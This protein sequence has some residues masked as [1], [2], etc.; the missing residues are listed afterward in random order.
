[1]DIAFLKL[2]L[3]WIEH[4]HQTI[5]QSKKLQSRSLFIIARADMFRGNLSHRS[6]GAAMDRIKLHTR[7][8]GLDVD[9]SQIITFPNGLPGFQSCRRWMLFHELDENG[10]P[11][12]GVVIHLQSVDDE[13]LS[14][15]LTEPNLFGFNY[16]MVLSESDIAEL[17]VENVADVLVLMILYRSDSA[18]P[19]PAVMPAVY[20]NLSAPILINV[21]SRL[22]MQKILG[23]KTDFQSLSN[24]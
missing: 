21:K 18:E 6:P 16:E 12:V 2:L 10:K 3:N 22:G 5:G 11:V 7:F 14:F 1:L 9:E 23:A 20:A 4:S 17:K 15:S 13:K 8:G 19:N 24:L